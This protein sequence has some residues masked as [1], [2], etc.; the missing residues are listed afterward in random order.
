MPGH[1]THEEFVAAAASKV[2]IVATN[3]LDERTPVLDGAQELFVLLPQTGISNEDPL[4]RDFV[5]IHSETEHLPIGHQANTWAPG[6]L[7]RIQPELASAEAWAK[8]IAFKACKSLLV[9][10]GV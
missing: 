3:I 10:F 2:C 7:A 4:Y 6:A 5:L 1:M 8:P 9:R